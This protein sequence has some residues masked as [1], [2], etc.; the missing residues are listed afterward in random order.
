MRYQSNKAA[1]QHAMLYISPSYLDS[2]KIISCAGRR[3]SAIAAPQ[4]TC[5]DA[6]QQQLDNEHTDESRNLDS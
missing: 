1:Y 3:R 6:L 4:H 2:G 5:V